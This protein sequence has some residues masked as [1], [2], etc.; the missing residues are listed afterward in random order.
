VRVEHFDL[1][2]ERVLDDN[3]RRGLADEPVAASDVE[4]GAVQRV[5]QD[6]RADDREAREKG[7]ACAER[8]AARRRVSMYQY[9]MLQSNAPVEVLGV[10][11]PFREP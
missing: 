5:R 2:E 3:A 6:A 9:V 10:R 8:A 11:Q 4:R 7:E 1:A